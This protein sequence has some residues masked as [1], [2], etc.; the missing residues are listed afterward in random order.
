MLKK[1]SLS[2]LN[3]HIVCVLCGGYFI[4]PVTLVECLHSCK[5]V[6]IHKQ[7]CQMVYFQNQKSQFG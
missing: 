2:D 6:Y 5:L 1:V 3:P 4:D 7:G